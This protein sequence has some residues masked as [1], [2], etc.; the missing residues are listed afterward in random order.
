VV[1]GIVQDNDHDVA[2]ASGTATRTR[3]TQ[4][5]APSIFADSSRLS[6]ICENAVRMIIR[7]VVLMA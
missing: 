3:I 7:F 4:S 2:F 1:N 5:F 6:G